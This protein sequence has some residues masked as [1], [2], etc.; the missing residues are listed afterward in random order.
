MERIA[1]AVATGEVVNAIDRVCDQ[2]T[3]FVALE[4]TM[5]SLAERDVF[6]ILHDP[7]VKD[8]AIMECLDRVVSGLF[9]VCATLGALPIIRCERVRA[10]VL[11]A[12]PVPDMRGPVPATRAIAVATI[13]TA[14]CCVCAG[15]PCGD[16][17]PEAGCQAT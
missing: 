7:A 15:R 13:I 12:A 8:T 17:G 5:F 14:G 10:H 6:P 2:F 11:P 9:S 3:G 4:P 1:A 16:G